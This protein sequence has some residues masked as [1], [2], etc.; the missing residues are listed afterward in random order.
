MSE[1]VELLLQLR[2]MYV[3]MGRVLE[4]IGQSAPIRDVGEAPDPSKTQTQRI[5][6]A[7]AHPDR[8]LSAK[9]IAVITGVSESAVRAALYLH[10]DLFQSVKR[11]PRR[12]VW[13]LVTPPQPSSSARE[14]AEGGK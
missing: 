9:Q 6:D 13:R 5:A 10:K 14:G 1:T 3:A 8:V 2:A 4:I 11:G 12:V 7:L